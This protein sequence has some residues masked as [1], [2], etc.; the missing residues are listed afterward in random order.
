V[1]WCKGNHAGHIIESALVGFIPDLQ[2]KLFKEVFL[3]THKGNFVPLL[4]YINNCIL[5]LLLVE[6]S[7]SYG[8]IQDGTARTRP[9]DLHI[10]FL[11]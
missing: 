8:N 4:L 6:N 1:A 10:V 2:E 3:E 5:G 9:T 7:L 11:L